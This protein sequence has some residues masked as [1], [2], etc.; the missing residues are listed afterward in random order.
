MLTKRDAARAMPI[1][2]LA[3]GSTLLILV[4]TLDVVPR[5]L[6]RS[7]HGQIRAAETAPPRRP[8]S[9]DPIAVPET[10][11]VAG[12]VVNAKEE[13]VAGARL[14]L[15]NVPSR[16]DSPPTIR[17]TT[18]A[19]GRFNLTIERSELAASR[20]IRRGLPGPI[21]A[22]FAEGHGP[23]WTD[24]LRVDDPD[25]LS[26][27]LAEDDV[28]VTGRMIDLEGRPI[29]GVTVRV[30][31]VDATLEGDLSPWLKEVAGGKPGYRSFN[32]FARPLEASLASPIHPATTGTDG[33]F[34]LAGVGKERLVSLLIQGPKTETQVLNVMTRRGPSATVRFSHLTNRK[35]VIY[36]NVIHAADFELVA[37]STRPVEGVVRDRDTGLP[38]PGVVVRADHWNRNS[39]PLVLY[40]M[41]DW[42]GTFLRT[43]TDAQGHYRITG[44]PSRE[45]VALRAD[46]AD[47]QPYHPATH[48]FGNTPGVGARVLDFPLTRGVLV[49]GRVTDRTTGAPVAALVEYHPTVENPNIG[50]RRDLARAEGRPTDADGRFAM[51]ALPGPGLIAATALGDRFVHA[52]VVGSGQ[53]GDSH[54]FPNVNGVTSPS[55]CHAF[56]AIAPGTVADAVVCDLTLTPG[57]EPVVTILDPDGEPLAGARVS[58]IPPADL[59]R[60]G[61]WQSREKARFPVTGLTDHRIRVVLIHHGGRRLAGSVAVRDSEPGSLVVRLRPWGTISGRLID[62]NGRPRPGV[63][64]SYL[65]PRFSNRS[66]L[67]FPR[68]VMTDGQGQFSFEGLVP[69]REYILNVA[70]DV[71]RPQVGEVHVLQPGEVKSLGDV[72]EEGP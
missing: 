57:P 66:M 32:H 62:G 65:G 18:E 36:E 35:S 68:D 44:L 8:E 71:P 64:L 1:L 49:R 23:A 39:F 38:L 54:P 6:A 55:R 26:L 69:G 10:L 19:D 40:P 58:G 48:E 50:Q 46:P 42:P 63:R 70:A 51:V 24:D 13:P 30:L 22:A 27:Q 20:S 14:Y 2:A 5:L 28:P 59:A 31:Q 25:G 34:R 72:R 3:A 56:A 45:T 9:R 21:V 17:A 47:G 53:T 12:R 61:W 15:G 33:R 4:A 41:T 67:F 52:D 7:G 11:A 29:S 37:A 16:E 43:T 60:E